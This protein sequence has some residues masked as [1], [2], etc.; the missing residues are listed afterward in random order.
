MPYKFRMIGWFV[1]SL[2]A[3]GIVCFLAPQQVGV[4]VY[5]LGLNFGS[6]YMGYWLDRSLFPYARPDSYLVMPYSGQFWTEDDANHPVVDG[7]RW[8]F[9]AAMLRRA[10]I[11]GA[12]MIGTAVAL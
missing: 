1:A 3:L 7:Y 5:K 4:A 9:A 2:V 10:F 8:V 6:G 12:A 11:V